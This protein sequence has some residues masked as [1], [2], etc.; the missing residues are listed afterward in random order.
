MKYI[1][2]CSCAK[3]HMKSCKKLLE[4]Y[5]PSNEYDKEVWL[6]LYYLSGYILEGLA[7]YSAYKLN[8][9]DYNK[10]IKEPDIEFTERTGLD[11]YKTRD[12]YYK[13][14]PVPESLL[15]R[16]P[17]ALCVQSHGFQQI[18][19]Q[20]LSKEPPFC[21]IPYFDDNALIDNDVYQLIESWNPKLRYKY[22]GKNYDRIK[23]FDIL[24]EDSVKKLFATCKKIYDLII[25]NI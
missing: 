11:F 20:L 9:W 12:K 17:E 7:V 6:E 8:D 10:D 22:A 3:K 14:H 16:G 23:P 19:K 15:N 21:D 1:E 4:D 2:Y 18:I 13:G 5:K 24:N 25:E